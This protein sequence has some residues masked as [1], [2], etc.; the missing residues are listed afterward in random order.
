MEN[1]EKESGRWL[2]SVMGGMIVLALVF[3]ILIS[4]T[5]IYGVDALFPSLRIRENWGVV[6]DFFGGILNP[7]FAFLGL[8]MLLAT[9]Y[10]SQKELSLTRKE[11][12]NS[13]EALK[14][15]ALTQRQQ[16]F[17]NTF[18]E[19]LN[20]H[21]QLI[22]DMNA[23]MHKPDISWMNLH[24]SEKIS[25]D[26]REELEKYLRSNDGSNL[27]SYFIVLFQMLKMLYIYFNG[28]ENFSKAGV[29]KLDSLTDD[30][31]RYSNI[32]RAFVDARL[33]C[34]LAVN[35]LSG[36]KGKYP[37]YRRFKSL[38]ERYAFFE[39]IPINYT[40]HGKKEFFEYVVDK[41]LF[42]KNVFGYG[43]YYEKVKDRSLGY[44]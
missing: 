40:E 23:L 15:Q 5:Y 10:Q 11:L 25:S 24:E 31:K 21:N 27:R 30:E 28:S 6:G 32:V 20:Q 14:D 43:Y 37:N 44:D 18:F 9:L 26:V 12:A 1:S 35:C 34:L 17:E 22:R 36:E 7:V 42:N 4:I 8:I 29:L 33:G 41:N 2:V 39:H 3:G 38:L 16:R 13:T 19:L